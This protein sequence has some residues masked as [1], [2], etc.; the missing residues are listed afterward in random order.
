MHVLGGLDVGQ[1][2]LVVQEEHQRGSLP[3]VERDGPLT[4]SLSGLLQKIDG[5]TG[6]VAGGRT[7]HS[8]YP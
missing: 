2:R 1:E 4:H 6:L 5:K 3:K 7:R 8:V